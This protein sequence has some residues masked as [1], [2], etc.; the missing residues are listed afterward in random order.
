MLV[1]LKKKQKVRIN[2]A[3]TVFE[4]MK[5]ILIAKD[6]FDRDKEHFWAIGLSR[7]N[8]IKY[9]D[10]VSVGSL[11][12]T[13]ACPREVFRM[14]VHKAAAALIVVHN[15]PSGNV[16]ASKQD[17]DITRQLRDAGKILQIEVLDSVIISENGFY[18]FANEGLLW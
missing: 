12:G 9:I 1:K 11:V 17:Q 2:S 16:D 4:I 7:K 5:E 8:M 15:H 13:I 18:S 3:L 6:P 10:Q 14:A